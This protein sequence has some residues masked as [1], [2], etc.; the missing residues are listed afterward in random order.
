MAIG[1][2]RSLANWIMGKKDSVEDWVEDSDRPNQAMQEVKRYEKSIKEYEE[3]YAEILQMYNAAD[4][5][6]KRLEGL[7][8]QLENAAT[9]YDSSGNQDKALECANKIVQLEQDLEVVRA[10]MA[11]HKKNVD[12]AQ[13]NWKK[14][15]TGKDEAERIARQIKSTHNVNKG[16]EI[17]SKHFDGSGLNKLKEMRERQVAQT[18]LLDAKDQISTASKEDSMESLI[19]GAAPGADAQ[20]QTVLAR[21]RAKR[22]EEIRS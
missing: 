15:I 21:I 16:R 12:I 6:A 13:T 8:R 2:G 1:F 9:G 22:S 5:E 17:T 19:A 7:I 18:Q 20:A 10:D 11:E 3:R 14:A 4:R